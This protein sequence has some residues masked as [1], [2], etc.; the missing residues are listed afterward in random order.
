MPTAVEFR[1]AG[2]L[3]IQ[4]HE[5]LEQSEGHSGAGSVASLDDPWCG[6]P[7]PGHPPIPHVDTA[8]LNAGTSSVFN[9][10]ALNPQP[11]PP[12]EPEAQQTNANTVADLG[13]DYCGTRP[14]GPV[15]PGPIELPAVQWADIVSLATSIAR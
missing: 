10:V 13:D 15:P 8:G 14:H 4:S 6:T 5:F 1:A 2:A 11:L 12:R 9:E 7:V 3:N